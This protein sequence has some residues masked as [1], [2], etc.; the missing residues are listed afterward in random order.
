MAIN[1]AQVISPQWLY[2]RRTKTTENDYK[3]HT[4]I[5]SENHKGKLCTTGDSPKAT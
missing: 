3:L 4:K 2:K 5:T 1:K